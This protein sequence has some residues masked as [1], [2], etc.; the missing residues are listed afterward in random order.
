MGKGLAEASPFWGM[1]WEVSIGCMGGKKSLRMLESIPNCP[2]VPN[3]YGDT[4]IFYTVD[5]QL[6]C[7]GL[8]T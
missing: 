4:Y 5:I 7:V 6:T 1:G 8:G 3:P 2:N